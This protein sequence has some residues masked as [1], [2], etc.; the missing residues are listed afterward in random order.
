[1]SKGKTKVSPENESLTVG[2]L[3]EAIKQGNKEIFNNPTVKEVINADFSTGRIGK[4]TKKKPL[5][6]I[7]DKV[8]KGKVNGTADDNIR[9]NPELV[10]LLIENGAELSD[11]GKRKLLD[12]I[13]G[14]KV[15]NDKRGEVEVQ[16]FKRLTAMPSMADYIERYEDKE[17]VMKAMH[18][19]YEESVPGLISAGANQRIGADDIDEVENTKC[20]DAVLKKVNEAYVKKSLLDDDRELTISNVYKVDGWDALADIAAQTVIDRNSGAETRGNYTELAKDLVAN[21]AKIGKVDMEVSTSVLD[22]DRKIHKDMLGILKDNIDFQTDPKKKAAA[23]QDFDLMKDALREGQAALKT[24]IIEDRAKRGGYK[25]LLEDAAHMLKKA[26]GMDV[27]ETER[28][29]LREKQ[30]DI[31]KALRASGSLSSSVYNVVTG[32]INSKKSN[33]G[34]G[35]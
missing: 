29:R 14:S 9:F 34:K 27:K 23:K 30:K 2:K 24:K 22:G 11:D 18:N 35:H 15:S 33:K 21:G 8:I 28:D 20:Q 16:L 26:V 32:N 6:Y 12:H 4:T 17:L 13:A 31:G 10:D 1:M 7:L 25:V 19:G 5:D 3:K